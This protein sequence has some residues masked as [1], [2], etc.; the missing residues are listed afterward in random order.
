MAATLRANGLALLAVLA[1]AAPEAARAAELRVGDP[2]PDVALEGADGRTWRLP[3][4]LA[5]GEGGGFVL[6]WFPKAF[7]SG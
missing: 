3:D 7:T 1:L 6:A 4:L 5:A 2:A